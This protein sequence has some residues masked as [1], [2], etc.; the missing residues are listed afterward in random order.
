VQF[1]QHDLVGASNPLTLAG[2]FLE[3]RRVFEAS[4]ARY[5]A[6]GS[7]RAA[8]F[9]QTISAEGL[10]GSATGGQ[11]NIGGGVLIVASSSI[12]IDLGATFGL[13]RFGE[14]NATF[15]EG[16][17]ITSPSASGTN[18]VLRAGLAIGLGSK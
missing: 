17:G 1:S 4:S 14:F 13:L 8:V 6:Y 11:L 18:F 2:V 7:L 16:G 5:A 10:S 9:R 3:P 12:N 15:A